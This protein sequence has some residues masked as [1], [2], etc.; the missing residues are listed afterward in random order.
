MRTRGEETSPRNK[1]VQST[2]KPEARTSRDI[3][4]R[5]HFH[6]VHYAGEQLR[7]TAVRLG[8]EPARMEGR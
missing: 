7:R 5:M 6:A 2:P 8:R 3:T 1:G 4:A